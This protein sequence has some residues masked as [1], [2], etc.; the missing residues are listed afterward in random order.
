MS[1]LAIF[2]GVSDGGVRDW[3]VIL[4][5]MVALAVGIKTLLT[6]KLKEME[7]PL[8]VVGVKDL[9]TRK[10]LLKV[11]H[12]LEEKLAEAAR[13]RATEA[14]GLRDEMTSLSHSFREAVGR[15]HARIDGLSEK[16]GQMK[17]S[18]D[19]M[20]ENLGRLIERS[21]KTRG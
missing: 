3:V 12:D 7:S 18:V 15:T 17:G 8:Q 21:L 10:E 19:A 9:A 4:A 5:G 14:K 1:I 6:K 11:E 2:E 13:M 20:N 16:T